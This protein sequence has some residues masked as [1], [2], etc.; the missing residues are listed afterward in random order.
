M[1]RQRETTKQYHKNK[2]HAYHSLGL[3]L[4]FPFQR[5][6]L[7]L[8]HKAFRKPYEGSLKVSVNELCDQ[9]TLKCHLQIIQGSKIFLFGYR[10]ARHSIYQTH[11]EHSIIKTHTKLLLQGGGGGGQFYYG[12]LWAGFNQI[13]LSNVYTVTLPTACANM[14]LNLGTGCIVRGGNLVPKTFYESI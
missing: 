2:I 11:S 6:S 5:T 7:M 1:S 8:R 13:C 4:T 3:G 10:P 14:C 12:V 9:V